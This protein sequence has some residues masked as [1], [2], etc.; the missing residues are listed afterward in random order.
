[1]SP[2]TESFDRLTLSRKLVGLLTSRQPQQVGIAVCGFGLNAAEQIAEA[3]LAALLANAAQMPDFRSD[4]PKPRRLRKITV[5]GAAPEHRFRRTVAELRGSSLARYLATLPS[6]EL[7]PSVYLKR[8]GLLARQNGLQM[9]FL[10]VA[11][12]KRKKAGAFLAVAQGSPKADAGII[13]L[14]YIPKG[15][16][17]Q[18]PVALVGKGICFDTGGVNVKPARFMLGMQGDMQGSAVALGSLLALAELEAW[19]AI[20]MNHIG[21]NAYKP[22]DVVTACNGTTIEVIHT[23]A[24]GR[25]V[26]ADSL[27]LCS[28]EKPRL[29]IDYATLTGSCVSAIGKSY[30]GVFT[31]RPDWWASLIALGRQAGE[32]IWPFP[33]DKDFD[34]ALESRIADIKQCAEEGPVDHILA[35]RFLSRFV[36]DGI[37]WIHLDLSS[38]SNRDGLAHVPTHFNGFGVRLTLELLLGG[39]FPWMASTQA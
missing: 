5:H 24:E 15:R 33:T 36:G 35:A 31:N 10:D 6:T 4:P 22:T 21:P 8:V 26:L 16:S 34:K 38:A 14:R 19:L 37:P 9:Q 3:A 20:A 23:D 11:T 28:R 13:R 25:M 39:K 1:M 32:R 2:S 7:T 30:S 17:R 18:A 27:A 29:I 12:L